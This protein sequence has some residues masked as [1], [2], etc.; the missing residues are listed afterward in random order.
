MSS[1][2]TTDNDSE[3]STNLSIPYNNQEINNIEKVTKAY[4]ELRTNA[5]Q[6]LN[7]SHN[8]NE[9]LRNIISTIN[10]NNDN[11]DEPVISERVK[12][13]I[14]KNDKSK[15]SLI[16]DYGINSDL[17]EVTKDSDK[18]IDEYKLLLS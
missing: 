6:T 1:N 9:I 5:L 4:R 16:Q 11:V 12:K 17:I 13:Y 18:I 14:V 8:L 7:D 3:I 2:P 15:N 10:D